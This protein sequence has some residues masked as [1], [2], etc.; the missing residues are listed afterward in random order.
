MLTRITKF[1]VFQVVKKMFIFPIEKPKYNESRLDNETLHNNIQTR[2][3]A[4]KRKLWQAPDG[5]NVEDI[6]SAVS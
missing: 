2:L 6:D 3:R 1:Q 5:L 4:N